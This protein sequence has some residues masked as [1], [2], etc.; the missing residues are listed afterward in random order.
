[1]TEKE[2]EEFVDITIPQQLFHVM[3][4]DIDDKTGGLLDEVILVQL[5]SANIGCL[6]YKPLQW[7]IDYFIHSEKIL[8]KNIMNINDEFEDILY[9]E[10]P[11][12]YLLSEELPTEAIPLTD[13]NNAKIISEEELFNIIINN[14]RDE[15]S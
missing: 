8:I 11:L 14:E 10:E 3:R 4:T 1:M 15:N 7:F 6:K 5:L 13:E 12:S 9:R 2:F